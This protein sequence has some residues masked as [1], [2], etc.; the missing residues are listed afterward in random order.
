MDPAFAECGGYPAATIAWHASELRFLNGIELSCR[1]VRSRS[2]ERTIRVY[3][4]HVPLHG[5]ESMG[6]EQLALATSAAYTAGAWPRY[7]H[8]VLP[9]D[10]L[11]VRLSQR[12]KPFAGSSAPDYSVYSMPDHEVD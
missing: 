4:V 6:A 11:Q 3:P 7:W 9:G 5:D 2:R 12:L 10:E 8:C 1:S